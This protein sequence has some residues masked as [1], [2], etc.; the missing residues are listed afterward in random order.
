[1]VERVQ[2]AS[3]GKGRQ[4]PDERSQSAGF[5]QVDGAISIN[6]A[7]TTHTQDGE[8]DAWTCLRDLGI[9]GDSL[10]FGEL[11]RMDFLD[12][13]GSTQPWVEC[14]F[15]SVTDDEAEPV[16]MDMSGAG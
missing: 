7:H 13:I 6:A 3:W 15:R 16:Q 12:R 11:G 14:S 5:R 9:S 4:E 1:M 8:R 10:T 2:A